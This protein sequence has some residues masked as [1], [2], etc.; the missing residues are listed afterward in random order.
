[1]ARSEAILA[2][3][4]QSVNCHIALKVMFYL[5]NSIYSTRLTTK[6]VNRGD[7]KRQ[8]HI[9]FHNY[10]YVEHRLQYKYAIHCCHMY[11]TRK[12]V[13]LKLSMNT[14]LGVY[15]VNKQETNRKKAQQHV[16]T[17]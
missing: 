8:T 13:C 14:V 16:S 15:Y 11:I 3:T 1:M 17:I 6:W 10:P 9:S 12:K 5:L 7:R 2:L 4:D